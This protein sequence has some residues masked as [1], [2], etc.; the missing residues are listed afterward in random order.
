M[1]R[2]DLLPPGQKSCRQT[3]HCIAWKDT[4]DDL[5]RKSWSN[6]IP[7]DQH[8][9]KRHVSFQVLCARRERLT[10]IIACRIRTTHQV[11]KRNCN[12]NT[13]IAEHPSM[14]AL[15]VALCS[16]PRLIRLPGQPEEP[17][18][19]PAHTCIQLARTSRERHLPVSVP[20]R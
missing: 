17:C 8:D 12:K 1:I 11:H 14:I 6:H 15:R 20:G 9:G 7:T 13:D 10:A 3:F 4:K 16:T 18:C 19:S 5:L 2:K